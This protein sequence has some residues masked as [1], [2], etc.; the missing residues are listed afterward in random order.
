MSIIILTLGILLSLFL[1]WRRLK[2]DYSSEIVF[3]SFFGMLLSGAIGS[4]IFKMISSRI[5]SVFYFNPNEL[6]FWGAFLGFVVSCLW[7]TRKLDLVFFEIF[8]AA[9]VSFILIFGFVFFNYA[10]ENHEAFSL[11]VFLFVLALVALFFFLDKKYKTFSWYK[12]GKVGFAGIF[13]SSLFF[14]A[15]SVVAIT[16]PNVISFVG[17]IDSLISVSIAFILF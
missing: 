2:E 12:S 7:I 17:R 14:L 6:W 8:E 11:I 16:V 3:K 10:V 1:Y 9:L 15:R 13:C 5:G 4:L